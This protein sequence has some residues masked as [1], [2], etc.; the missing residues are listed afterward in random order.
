MSAYFI[1]ALYHIPMEG[2]IECGAPLTEEEFWE[3][4]GVCDDCYG[5][6]VFDHLGIYVIRGY[7]TLD[8]EVIPCPDEDC[9]TI[10]YGQT[11]PCYRRPRVA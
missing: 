10:L 4:D 7:R 3:N 9:A 5:D 1:R 2:C 11:D 6:D 8:E